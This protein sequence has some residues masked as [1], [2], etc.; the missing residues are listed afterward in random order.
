[1]TRKQLYDIASYVFKG[2]KSPWS[3]EDCKRVFDVYFDYYALYMKREHPVISLRQLQ[4]ILKR[5][6]YSGGAKN[7]KLSPEDYEWMIPAYFLTPFDCDRN[8]SHFFSGDIRY[9]RYLEKLSAEE[10]E[11]K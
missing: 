7:Y 10:E 5:M 11:E 3:F 8:I 1:M 9:F 6:P 4:D 2:M